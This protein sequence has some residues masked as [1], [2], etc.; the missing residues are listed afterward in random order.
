MAFC[1]P[2]IS[3]DFTAVGVLRDTIGVVATSLN[4]SRFVGGHPDVG[5]TALDV[6]SWRVLAC[7]TGEG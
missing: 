5:C 1:V 3:A 4:L 7:G 6:P 2:P